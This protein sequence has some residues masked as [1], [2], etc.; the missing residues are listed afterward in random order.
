LLDSQQCSKCFFWIRGRR[1]QST[2]EWETEYSLSETQAR[3]NGPTTVRFRPPAKEPIM[4]GDCRIRSAGEEFP[5]RWH[6]DGCGEFKK[7]EAVQGYK[8]TA[9]LTTG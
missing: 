2:G 9:H 6:D 1:D 4:F 7:D 3:K 8:Q 5:V